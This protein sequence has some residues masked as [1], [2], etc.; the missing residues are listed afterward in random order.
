MREFI[1]RR[2]EPIC[3]TLESYDGYASRDHWIYTEVDKRSQSQSQHYEGTLK[4]SGGGSKVT[5]KRWIY[6]RVGAHGASKAVLRFI[7]PPE[8]KGVALLIVNHPDRASDQWMWTPAINRE[9]RVALQDR[10][11]RFF[12]TDFSFE[13]LEER[14]VSQYDYKMLGDEAIEGVQCW[15]LQSTPKKAKSSQY[16]HS[17]VWVRKDHYVVARIEGYKNEKLVRSIDYSD[18]TNVQGYWTP[19]RL[20]VKD[21]GRKSQTLLTLDKLQFNLPMKDE[22]F[23]LQG[24]RRQS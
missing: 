19:R 18:V 22:D 16:T 13:D 4:V 11:T 24:L 17:Y 8:V 5:E 14:D 6:D 10:S 2:Q 15:K 7:A 20:E 3:F 9:R 1:E 23:T 21:V 12:G